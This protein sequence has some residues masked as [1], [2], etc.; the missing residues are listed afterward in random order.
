MQLYCILMR[1]RL[2]EAYN[3][4]LSWI[5]I[6]SFDGYT[7]LTGRVSDRKSRGDTP[8]TKPHKISFQSLLVLLFAKEMGVYHVKSNLFFSA[9]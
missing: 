3:N 6:L 4:R 8:L 1:L 7:R 9:M 2:E 5:S